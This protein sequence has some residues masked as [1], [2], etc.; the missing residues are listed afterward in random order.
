V[1]TLIHNDNI[2]TES[3]GIIEYLDAL[4]PDVNGL[5]PESLVE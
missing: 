2:L 4:Y 3:T 5:L 1:P